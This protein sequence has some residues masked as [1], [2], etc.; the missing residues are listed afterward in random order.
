M[1]GSS[2]VS[3]LSKSSAG[4]DHPT[5]VFEYSVTS[6]QAMQT[7]EF[8]LLVGI[9]YYIGTRIGF[10]LTP[11]GQPISFFWPPNAILLA[12]FLLAPQRMWWTFLVAVLPAHLLAQ[13]QAGVP[14]WTAAGWFVSNT[15]EA[16]I[17]A[18][19]ITRVADRK[20]LF[21]TVRG[22]LAFIF[23]GVLI[24]PL[25]TSFL[26]AAAVVIT[27]WGKGYWP[28]G[29]TR[30][31]TN[32][33][34]ALTIV[35]TIVIY[36]SRGKSWIR[37]ASL[38]RY[39][40]SALL[41]VG[42]VLVTVLIFGAAGASPTTSPA[43]LYV[44]LPLL[45]WATIRFGSGGL[46][47]SLLLMVLIS[48][49][50]TMHGREPFPYASIAQ[51]IL[52]LQILFCMAVVPLMFLSAVMSEA[53]RT[54][55]SL[56]SVSGSLIQAQEQERSR[57]ARELHDDINQRLAMLAIEL[58]KVRDDNPDLASEVK[59]RLQELQKE[60]TEISSDVQAVSHELHSSRLEYLGLE[61]GMKSW[62]KE[63]GER[64]GMEVEFTSHQVS[65]SVPTEVSLCLFRVL[66]EALHNAVKY[67]GVKR[68]EVQLKEGS[69]QIHLVVKDSGKGFDPD[70]A[71]QGQGLGLT[72][73][74]ERVRLLNGTTLIESRPLGGTTIHA[75]VPI[76][77]GEASQ[78]ATG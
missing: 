66:Q 42:T 57:M 58:E 32:A 69:S 74:Q 61:G 10:A 20:T 8:A 11:S 65:S 29:A 2:F 62:C 19:C 56:R 36:G 49:W 73:M 16:L 15:S 50:F 41:A 3:S 17:G 43:L 64:Q 31:W 78:R 63:F 23:F 59:K 75:Q 18:F 13:H 48:I 35:P 14:V 27:G 44:P 55:E 72:S 37:N 39:G 70:A 30:F 1:A 68:I 34:A 4:V 38:A 47:L 46:S 60:T 67:S 53:R 12:A 22:V 28:L 52:S 76:R 26:D 33:M 51:N 6:K 77:S 54:Q 21:E 71:M 5:S 25:A 24:A 7:A 9:G 45:L 40:E